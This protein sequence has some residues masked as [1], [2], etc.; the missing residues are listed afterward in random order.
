MLNQVRIDILFRIVYN[1]LFFILFDQICFVYQ[2]RDK[3]QFDQ[4]VKVID[5]SDVFFGRILGFN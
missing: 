4:V 2:A 5:D 1:C 3:M